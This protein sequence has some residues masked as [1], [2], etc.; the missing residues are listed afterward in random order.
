[1][2]ARTSRLLERLIGGVRM[3]SNT[4]RTDVGTDGR[5]TMV[6]TARNYRDLFI[7]PAAF[8]DTHAGGE[9]LTGSVL[10]NVSGS[11]MAHAAGSGLAVDALT[12]SATSSSPRYTVA[13]VPVPLDADTSGSLQ[14][15]VDF[16]SHDTFANAGSS[17]KFHVGAAY[18][19]GGTLNS[20]AC[21]IRTAAC[22]EKAASYSAAASGQ[23][24]SASL[25]YLPSFGSADT[26]LAV[27][28]GFDDNAVNGSAAADAGS[29]VAI[30]GVRLRY[31]AN[32]LG[33]QS[34]E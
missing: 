23:F 3:G 6:G 15:F 31:L 1:M 8:R 13:V 27:V 2:P 21:A 5:Q 29:A 34:A 32:K 33:S 9:I 16:T 17:F 30:L 10:M 11:I 14:P 24:M 7:A 26:M 19:K 22:V 4:N 18:F 25:P 20:T 28:V 12:A